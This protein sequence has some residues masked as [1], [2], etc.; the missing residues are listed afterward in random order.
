MAESFHKEMMPPKPLHLFLVSNICENAPFYR[1]PNYFKD[2]SPSSEPLHENEILIVTSPPIY[3]FR[4]RFHVLNNIAVQPSI[5]NNLPGFQDGGNLY[6]GKSYPNISTNSMP[7]RFI[8]SKDVKL[9]RKFNV[10]D[11]PSL[12]GTSYPFVFSRTKKLINY[13]L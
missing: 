10:L 12:S 7:N 11:S 5:E 9:F 8:I 6:L 1:D 2:S 3:F 4:I 13:T